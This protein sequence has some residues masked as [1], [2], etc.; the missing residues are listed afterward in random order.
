M[1]P[2]QTLEITSSKKTAYLLNS[3]RSPFEVDGK[4]WPT[5]THY[6]AAMQF[7]GTSYEEE[8]RKAS[9]IVQVQRMVSPHYYTFD[10][11][12][13]PTRKLVY[14]KGSDVFFR[15]ADWTQAEPIMLEKALRAKFKNP[16]LLSQ[17]LSTKD[18]VLAGPGGSVL[19]RIRDEILLK[20]PTENLA[21]PQIEMDLR[22]VH[23]SPLTSEEKK[24][25]TALM[26]LSLRIRDLE[27]QN[28]LY[29]EMPEDALMVLGGRPLA[30]L[31]YM[32]LNKHSWTVI[33][34]QMPHFEKLI[35][36]THELIVPLDEFQEHQ[37]QV[38]AVIASA[39]RWWRLNATES[40]KADF[41]SKLAKWEN[42]KVILPKGKRWYRGSSPA[43]TEGKARGKRAFSEGRK[44]RR[45][46]YQAGPEVIRTPKGKSPNGQKG[47]KA[48]PSPKG[49]KSPKEKKERVMS[50][51]L[52]IRWSGKDNF[53]VEGKTL[54]KYRARLLGLGGKHPMVRQI[55]NL[56]AI[57][58]PVERLTAVEEV[59][60]E[61]LPEDQK[62][63]EA[64]QV[65]KKTKVDLFTDTAAQLQVLKGEKLISKETVQT[66]I[67]IYGCNVAPIEPDPELVSG[68]D[69][70]DIMDP[71]AIQ[72]LSGVVTALGELLVEH[73]G[74]YAEYV[75]K[76]DQITQSVM[77]SSTSAPVAG[78]S[79][80]QMGMLRAMVHI[81]KVA[82]YE[83][84][85]ETFVWAFLTVFPR[86]GRVEAETYVMDLLEEALNG[87]IREVVE[88][89]LESPRVSWEGVEKVLGEMLEEEVNEVA[90]VLVVIALHY[91]S[92][93]LEWG[94][95]ESR[96]LLLRI[97]V[98][99]YAYQPR[100]L[101]SE[102]VK[103]SRKSKKAVV[104][105][106]PKMEI[107]AAIDPKSIRRFKGLYS[108]KLLRPIKGKSLEEVAQKAAENIADNGAVIHE[109]E[110]RD[111][112]SYTFDLVGSD[113]D[114]SHWRAD[115]GDMGFE[116]TRIQSS[117]GETPK[118]VSFEESSRTSK[119]ESEKLP[120]Y[121][122]KK[123][124]NLLEYPVVG[125][126]GSA[127]TIDDRKQ[128]RVTRDVHK[129]L[130]VPMSFLLPGR[131]ESAGRLRHDLGWVIDLTVALSRKEARSEKSL[132]HRQEYLLQA[133]EHAKYD[134]VHQAALK[135]PGVLP[136]L[137]LAESQVQEYLPA[138]K[139]WAQKNKFDLYIVKGDIEEPEGMDLG[140][141]EFNA[142]EQEKQLRL[143]EY[144]K[145][146]GP[147]DLDEAEY[148]KVVDKLEA[149]TSQER[150]RFLKKSGK[151]LEKKVRLLL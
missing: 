150:E 36:K 96:H 72:Y 92:L 21:Q 90:K 142:A 83:P 108:K 77:D 4:V 15:R 8:I 128:D 17:L 82:D 131:S 55:P 30:S 61:D 46:S 39:I 2:S 93:V 117:T 137:A 43:L 5:V 106:S 10:D 26:K 94:S 56:E 100:K 80:P 41:K 120:K 135:S 20:P 65:W 31:T 114:V 44:K 79:A 73:T 40:Q 33:Y 3:Y 103:H 49:K 22:D 139:A 74:S 6:M 48:S 13:T 60:F 105:E 66:A 104:H 42:L 75:H 86:K 16:K 145:V 7:P 121:F 102:V 68:L 141:V 112:L 9:S 95:P 71:E 81:L 127:S 38:S 35:Q 70:L 111:P 118:K 67:A 28:Y 1:R 58:F 113:E 24:L 149:L 89:R 52:T 97:K 130:K 123:K 12:G 69:M 109:I 99:G 151:E 14:G 18:L 85:S 23:A 50:D 78:L 119:G 125:V 19:M 59:I 132:K 34:Q 144:R 101:S 29:A 124:G 47:H 84:G 110:A 51:H 147:L 134:I 91:T 63:Q 53:L 25:V 27:G 37:I 11:N 107:S 98:L 129:V 143:K 57:R 76:L 32:W 122:H 87:D 116:V 88:R 138:L 136:G 148:E 45:K 64:F 54:P 126:L 133:L 140:K 62:Y 115:M 146:I